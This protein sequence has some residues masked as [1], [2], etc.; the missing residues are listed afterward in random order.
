MPEIRL[1]S[2]Y[3]RHPKNI[4]EPCRAWDLES[5]PRHSYIHMRGSAKHKARV[6]KLGERVSETRS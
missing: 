3:S 2:D 6:E 5:N 1:L 4:L